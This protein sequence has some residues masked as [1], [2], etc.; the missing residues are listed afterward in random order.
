MKNKQ[1]LGWILLGVGT[2]ILFLGIVL[3]LTL[4]TMAVPVCFVVSIIFNSAGVLV[5]PRPPRPTAQ[6]MGSTK[7]KKR[8]KR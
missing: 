1:R 8:K 4:G 7:R 3:A 6:P 5:L 2:G